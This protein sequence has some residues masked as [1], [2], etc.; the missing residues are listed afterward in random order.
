[1]INIQWL[2][3]VLWSSI[4]D[5]NI[6]HIEQLFKNYITFIHWQIINILQFKTI[7]FQLVINIYGGG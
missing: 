2:G 6:I 4:D 1:M 3:G 5:F 7:E